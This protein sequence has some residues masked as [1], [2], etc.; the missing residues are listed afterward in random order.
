KSGFTLFL[1]CRVGVVA[2]GAV[3][4]KFGCELLDSARRA[5]C[6]AQCAVRLYICIFVHSSAAIGERK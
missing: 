4:R 6:L 5:V 1:A 2:Q 3:C